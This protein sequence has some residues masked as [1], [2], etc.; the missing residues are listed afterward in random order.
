MILSD[1][2]LIDAALKVYSERLRGLENQTDLTRNN[3]ARVMELRSKK[4][5]SDETG[6][7]IEF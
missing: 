1:T 4:I 7:K 3:L 2:K 5:T 6:V